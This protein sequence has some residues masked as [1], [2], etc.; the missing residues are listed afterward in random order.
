MLGVVGG[1]F[2]LGGTFLLNLSLLFPLTDA[3]LKPK[4]TPVVGFDYVF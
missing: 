2:N 1:K 4:P 3:G